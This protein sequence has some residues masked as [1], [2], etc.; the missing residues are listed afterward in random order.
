M[1]R[2]SRAAKY[3]GTLKLRAFGGSVP[4]MRRDAHWAVNEYGTVLR[5]VKETVRIF[6]SI[7]WWTTLMMMGAL[8]YRARREW[9]FGVFSVFWVYI[10]Y[11]LCSSLVLYPLT[12]KSPIVYATAYWISSLISVLIGLGVTWEIYR[13]VF[14]PYVGVYRLGRT[15]TAALCVVVGAKFATDVS[16]HTIG[17]LIPTTLELERNL[18]FVQA[19]L[20]L[21]IVVLVVYYR[22]PLGR[23]VGCLF[24]GYALFVGSAVAN[25][26]LRSACGESFQAWW[27][28]LQPLEYMISVSIWCIGLWARSPGPVPSRTLAKDYMRART[29]T[30]RELAR[31]RTWLI[32]G[33]TS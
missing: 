9:R 25:L 29:E 12:L 27:R 5:F 7:V 21:V 19:L 20:L 1:G 16:T 8:L 14:T 4:D 11:V 23:N 33:S 30:A 3:L 13:I 2:S 6:T 15:L 26:S 17:M 10:G 24:G 32:G 22:V 28:V 31:L 18:R